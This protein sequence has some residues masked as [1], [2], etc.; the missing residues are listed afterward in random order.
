M[1][2]NNKKTSKADSILS[3]VSA[4]V[5]AEVPKPLMS[6]SNIGKRKSGPQCIVDRFAVPEA[7]F[8]RQPGE[9]EKDWKR[10]VHRLQKRASR[11]RLLAT[12]P[13]GVRLTREKENLKLKEKRLK[14]KEE[15]RFLRGKRN[16]TSCIDVCEI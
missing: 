7:D 11:K 14:L 12:N 4:A 2:N 13:E 5:A 15:S 1:E 3:H 6:S 9:T 16:E 10:R 8:E